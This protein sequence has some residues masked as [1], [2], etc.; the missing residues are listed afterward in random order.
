LSL[1]WIAS[2]CGDDLDPGGASGRDGASGNDIGPGPGAEAGTSSGTRD[3]AAGTVGDQKTAFQVD[4]LFDIDNS[5]SMGDKQTLLE[6]AIPDL[7][8]RLINPNCVDANGYSQ[9]PSVAGICATAGT[10]AEFSAVHDMHLGIVS[11]SLGMR[12][13]DLCYPTQMT[14]NGMPFLDGNPSISSHTDDQGHLL[15]RSAPAGMA[16]ANA[17]T[18]MPS[19]VVGTQ[20]FIDW[21]PP[22]MPPNPKDPTATVGV[23]ALV[24][25]T[26][27]TNPAKLET[28]FANLVTGV[29]AFGCGIESQLESWYRFLVQ[30]D[31]YASIASQ[32]STNPPPGSWVGY[33]HVIIQQ[34]HD[35]LRPNSLVAIL[36]LSDENDSEIDTRSLSGEAVNWMVSGFSPAKGTSVCQTNPADPG[37]TSCA[38]QTAEADPNCAAGSGT[39]T[40][41]VD[42]GNNTTSGSRARRSPIARWSIPRAPPSI[43]A[44]SRKK[45]SPVIRDSGTARTRC[46][47]RPILTGRLRCPTART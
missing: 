34:R 27:E 13:G 20:N 5:A 44:A 38:Y 8:N 9:G 12:G 16:P 15:G 26:V 29:H 4:L 36:V 14:N 17:E 45:G 46:S 24:P 30:P 28:D 32:T 3:A 40:S 22:V 23:Q 11:S 7:V 19:P 39:Y 42:W 43:R 33:D 2:A 47:L 25:A 37:C 35:F 10:K 21:F 6:L 41:P 31:P 1:G 18:E